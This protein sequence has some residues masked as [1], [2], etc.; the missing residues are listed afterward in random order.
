[1]ESLTGISQGLWAFAYSPNEVSQKFL[2]SIY[3]FVRYIKDNSSEEIIQKMIPELRELIQDWEQLS[4]SEKSFN[5]IYYWQ[6]WFRYF[7]S[8]RGHESH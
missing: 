7:C 4:N 6:I 8:M 5:R 3:L 2:D 1:L